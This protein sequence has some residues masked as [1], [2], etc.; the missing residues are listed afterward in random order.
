M[1]IRPIVF[2]RGIWAVATSLACL[3]IPTQGHAQDTRAAL[4]QQM[5]A[6]PGDTQAMLA[7]AKAATVDRD[8]EAVVSTLERLLDIEPD[9][10][11]ARFELGVAYYA[12]GSYE[13]A[14]F[15]FNAVREQNPSAVRAQQIDGYLNRI[16]G[17]NGQNGLSGEIA[18][19]A[20]HSDDGGLGVVRGNL[21]WSVDLGQSDDH[22]WQ[23]DL[24]ASAY[25]GDDDLST[26]RFSLRTGPRFSVD[27]L[28]F[29][30][31]L[32]PYVEAEQISDSDG[33]DYTT[34][35]FGAQYFN[36]HSAQW[37][38][39]AD[40]KFGSIDGSD[41][42]SD[43]SFTA[44]AIGTSYTPSRA[45]RIRLTAFYSDFD[46]DTDSESYSR[47]GLRADIKHAFSGAAFGAN[48][49][50]IGTAYIQHSMVDYSSI[51]RE[52]DITSV[53]VSYRQFLRGDVF[54][55][56]GARYVNRSSSESGRDTS[57]PIVSL[58]IGSEF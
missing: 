13:L 46:T 50:S 52:D 40:L 3:V 2:Q 26:S 37:S 16:D 15:H 7:F 43:G 19:G 9:N 35:S 24:R 32:R 8:Y 23:T 11:E 48:R 10:A 53:G 58:M 57:T 56:L 29:G 12:L 21:R 47:K 54:V 30:V 41:G 17:R 6:A 27:G 45:T 20:A 25:S 18:V 5:L 55:E 49:P 34:L 28:A 36:A 38:S 22:T 39:F 4:F 14:Q 51:D 31:R 42:A 44:L 1:T 33:N